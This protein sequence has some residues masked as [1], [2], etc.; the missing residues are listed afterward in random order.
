MN[1][2]ETY[3][4]SNNQV[5][6]RCQHSFK[7]DETNQYRDPLMHWPVRGLA[8]SNEIGAAIYSLYPV[9]GMALWVPALT[10]IGA[11]VYDKYKN[12]ETE[13]NPSIKRGVKQAVFQ[14]SASVV[15]PTMAVCYGQKAFSSLDKFTKDGLS[16]QS[17]ID[18]INMSLSYIED[19]DL[20]S[21]RDKSYID[22]FAGYVEEN[23]VKEKNKINSL[24][25]FKKF[26]SHLNPLKDTDNI[27]R[28]D[29][30]KLSVYAKK[31][32]EEIAK[33][34]EAL[35]NN[36]KPDNMSDKL[37]DK[38]KQVKKELEAKNQKDAL[39]K[40]IT[41]IIKDYHNDKIFKNKILKTV[42]GFI[43]LALMIKPIDKFVETVVIKKAIEPAL[44]YFSKEN[45]TDEYSEAA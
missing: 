21:I 8:Y 35:S 12:D 24:S 19:N 41:N 26:L 43:S 42:G 3:T 33:I 23:H 2:I 29:N 1:L 28:A 10:Y 39:N 31:H 20:S 40:A 9:A 36:K 16:S 30:S 14:S 27:S 34:Y 22:K 15:L 37:F 6:K 45:Q 18:V 11:D 4:K 38:F 32:A 25:P 5:E 17:K 13:Y 7:E 44:D